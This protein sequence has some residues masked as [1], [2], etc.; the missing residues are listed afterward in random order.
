VQAVLP[1]LD[2]AM[3]SNLVREASV[4]IA[5]A[6]TQSV[7]EPF[8]IVRREDAPVAI[9]LKAVSVL[10][11]DSTAL[12]VLRGA[13]APYMCI[14]VPVALRGATIAVVKGVTSLDSGFWLTRAYGAGRCRRHGA[15][16]AN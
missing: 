6:S 13:S 15:T 16:V 12:V 1:Q 10:G 5:R 8:D 11:M 7:V 3:I 2:Q 14:Q 4:C 9:S